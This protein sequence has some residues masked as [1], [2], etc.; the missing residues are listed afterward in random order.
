[1]KKIGKQF[2]YL[3]AAVMASLLIQGGCAKKQT[4]PP[5]DRGVQLFEDGRYDEAG[6]YYDSVLTAT[7]ADAEAAVYLGRIALRQDDYNQ[8]IEWMETALELAP[9]SSNVHYWAARA[10]VVKVQ[11]EQAIALVGKVQT[12]LQTAVELDPANVEARMF[13]AGFYLNAPPIA[14]GSVKKAK[15]QAG[16]IV[17]YDPF[18]GHLF[19]ADVHK[20]EKDFDAAASDYAAASTV[21]PESP[22]P[23]YQLGMM[24]QANEQ[25]DAAFKA[26]ERAVVVD[27]TATYALYQIGRTG[28]FSGEN[29][30]RA[31]E[32]L[33]LY[34]QSDP[35][36]GQPTQANAH[37]RLGLIY[38]KQGD[39]EA[40]KKEYEAALELNP[41]DKNAKEALEKLTAPENADE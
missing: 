18:R 38:E 23:Y 10:Y 34:I 28:V 27:S 29:L 21:D 16:I 25:Y 7:P 39:I 1:M 14:G 40:A 12:H 37:W 4:T 36:P 2:M 30:D 13:L 19:M 11:A 33:R 35:G 5:V 24:Y 22:D 15:E 41:D 17:T 26:L 8:A 6:A 20:K 3:A 31:I 32:C 9:D